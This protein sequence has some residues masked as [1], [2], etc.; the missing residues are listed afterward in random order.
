MVKKTITYID[1][2]GK[3]RVEDFYFNLTKREA[4]ELELSIPGGFDSLR[5]ELSDT[6]RGNREIVRM[7]LDTYK[8]IIE[9]AVGTKTADGTKFIKPADYGSAFIV[10]DAYSE[11]ILEL[12]NNDDNDSLLNF[13]DEMF[14]GFP[15]TMKEA[16][17]EAENDVKKLE[18][19]TTSPSVSSTPSAL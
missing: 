5:E 1:F 3:T 10:S 12:M 11:L 8:I 9:K 6:T 15:M 4:A 18:V 19:N 13:F 7:L 16:A 17:N 2:D 14:V